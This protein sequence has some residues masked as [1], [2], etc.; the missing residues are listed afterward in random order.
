MPV[1]C[2]LPPCPL[3][4]SRPEDISLEAA[5]QPR[6]NPSN[7]L[8][9][10]DRTGLYLLNETNLTLTL[11]LRRKKIKE[12][13]ITSNIFG[14]M[15]VIIPYTDREA[16]QIILNVV[17]EANK[18]ALPDIQGSLRAYE[19][20]SEEKSAA[21][22][23]S[24]DVITG[25][26]VL[27]DDWRLFVLEGLAFGGMSS[28]ASQI[29]RHVSQRGSCTVLYSSDINFPRRLYVDFNVDLKLIRLRGNLSR[30][31]MRPEIYNHKVVTADCFETLQ[32]I[33]TIRTMPDLATAKEMDQFP[34]AVALRLVELLY[35]E[36]VSLADLEGKAVVK[37]TLEDSE[38]ETF[39]LEENLRLRRERGHVD[40]R[41]ESFEEHLKKSA[42]TTKTDFIAQHCAIRKQ[43]EEYGKSS[44]Q[45]RLIV[46]KEKEKVL[47]SGKLH[48]RLTAL[49]KLKGQDD[50]MTPTGFMFPKPRTTAEMRALPLRPSEARIEDLQ[51]PFDA[52]P[53]MKEGKERALEEREANFRLRSKSDGLFGIPTPLQFT[54]EFDRSLIGDRNSLPRGEQVSKPTKDATFFKSIHSGGK[55][56]MELLKEDAERVKA[57]WGSKV[58]V[59]H[60]HFKVT[61]YLVKDTCDPVDRVQGILKGKPQSLT[62]KIVHKNLA[63]ADAKAFQR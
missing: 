25:F 27:D 15:V 19:L 22:S 48:G 14:R 7:L 61:G 58:I 51:T 49:N 57:E 33:A 41:N 36:T 9:S 13:P 1:I 43:A 32:Q 20:T 63:I 54:H 17:A 56:M 28:A 23:G 16:L 5:S 4:W 31:I 12:N 44:L 53:A 38:K 21:L 30:L 50:W 37:M 29:M 42:Q 46:A 2:T 24:L 52:I 18:F 45:Q 47:K 26:S 40:C 10:Q 60:L 11:E 39:R 35:G 6:T 55:Q 8:S 3:R 59:D 34:S 62:S